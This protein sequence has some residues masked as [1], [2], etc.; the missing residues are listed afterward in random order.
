[1]IVGGEEG[2]HHLPGPLLQPATEGLTHTEGFFHVIH[3]N[4]E[5]LAETG[6]CSWSTAMYFW[7]QT[8]AVT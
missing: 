3:M 1:M 7:A 5:L 4:V 6:L 2:R 8:K